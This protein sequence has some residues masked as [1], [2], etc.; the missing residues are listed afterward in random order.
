MITDNTTFTRL[1]SIP[2]FSNVTKDIR[3][4]ASP[5]LVPEMIDI[6]H[7]QVID[8]STILKNQTAAS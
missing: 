5:P 1:L 7:V 6:I 2:C 3:S 8:V 4:Q